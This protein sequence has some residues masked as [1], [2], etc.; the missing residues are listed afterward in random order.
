MEQQTNPQLPTFTENQ[1]VTKNQ[2]YFELLPDIYRSINNSMKTIIV[3]G[4]LIH[5]IAIQNVKLKTQLDKIYLSENEE[6]LNKKPFETISISKRVG[7]FFP[8]FSFF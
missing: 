6:I 5:I 4:P 8:Y 7:L 2:F 1:T 3:F